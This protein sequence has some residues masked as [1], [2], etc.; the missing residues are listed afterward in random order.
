M[1]HGSRKDP[2][3]ACSGRQQ[4]AKGVGLSCLGKTTRDTSPLQELICS[5]PHPASH[6]KWLQDSSKG[7][8]ECSEPMGECSPPACWARLVGTG[9][10]IAADEEDTI[11]GPVLVLCTPACL[12]LYC[13]AWT[14]SRST[15]HW[16]PTWN[17]QPY[18]SGNAPQHL[19]AQGRLLVVGCRQAE[20]VPAARSCLQMGLGPN[21]PGCSLVWSEA[22]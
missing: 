7:L 8:Q 11:L 14:A 12:F 13:W 22:A 18:G 20:L 9:M 2:G 16:S 19:Q 21:R 3:G 17:W 1:V 10:D 15:Q 6:P 5:P 4:W